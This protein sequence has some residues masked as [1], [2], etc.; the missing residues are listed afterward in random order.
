MYAVGLAFLCSVADAFWK[1]IDIFSLQSGL[2]VGLCRRRVDERV[3]VIISLS[4]PDEGLGC[5]ITLTIRSL[6]LPYLRVRDKGRR[7]A[8]VSE[9]GAHGEARIPRNVADTS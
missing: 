3:T 6:V 1:T 8:L 4:L 5:D 2:E 9:N 7:D